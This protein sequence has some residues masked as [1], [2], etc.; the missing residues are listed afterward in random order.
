MSDGYLLSMMVIKF[1]N[2]FRDFLALL[3]PYGAPS[4]LK[5]SHLIPAKH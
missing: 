1:V 5:Y 4:T 3:A 2:K